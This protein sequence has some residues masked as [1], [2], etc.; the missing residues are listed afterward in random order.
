MQSNRELTDTRWDPIRRRRP[1]QALVVTFGAS[2]TLVAV[3]F[4]T[5]GSWGLVALTPAIATLYLLRRAV[6]TLADLPDEVL[7]ERLIAER[8]RVYLDSYRILAA[9]MVLLLIVLSLAADRAPVD[10]YDI[11]AVFWPLCLAAIGLPSAVLAWTAQG[12]PFHTAQG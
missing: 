3:V 4:W 7:D 5:A 12:E 9:A 10:F 2:L 6:R 1:R 11:S 8:N